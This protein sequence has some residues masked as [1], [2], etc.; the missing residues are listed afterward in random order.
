MTFTHFF[1]FSYRLTAATRIGLLC[2]LILTA[3]GGATAQEPQTFTH[4]DLV[5]TTPFVFVSPPAALSAG[6]YLIIENKG[7]TDEVLIGATADFADKTEV[8][9]MK[10]VDDIMKMRKLE[11]GLLIPAGETVALEPGGFHMMFMGLSQDLI[12][13][14]TL[15]GTLQFREAGSVNIEYQV[16]DR[17][18]HMSEMN[19]EHH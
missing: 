7:A 11:D 2:G 10:M 4:Q 13:G 5:I 18:K 14:E 3:A 6:G 1:S 8:H 9:E 19:H 16:V 15:Q 12:E 17:K